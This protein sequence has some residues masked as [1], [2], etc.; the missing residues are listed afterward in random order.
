MNIVSAKGQYIFTNITIFI[1]KNP[2][3]LV[4][5]LMLEYMI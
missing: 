1:I 4:T 5:K 2:N 3:E